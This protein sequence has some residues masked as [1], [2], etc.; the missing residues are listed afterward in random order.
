MLRSCIVNDIL[1]PPKLSRVKRQCARGV[2]ALVTD[3][4]HGLFTFCEHSMRR[5]YLAKTWREG[6]RN[7]IERRFRARGCHTIRRTI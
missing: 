6:R 3:L 2:S 5:A 7:N 4:R 1:C